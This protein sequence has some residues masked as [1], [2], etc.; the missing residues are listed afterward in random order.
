MAKSSKKSKS[1]LINAKRASRNKSNLTSVKSAIKAVE[2]AVLENNK[3][4]AVQQLN[5]AYS[6]LDMSISRRLHH[7]NYV[8]RQ[9]ARLTK[10]IN[11]LK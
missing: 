11:N 3:E 7:R 8:A 6:L 10:A 2:K 1:D 4:S 9:K 5:N